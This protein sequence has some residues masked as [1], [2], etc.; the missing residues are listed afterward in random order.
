MF[1]E[2]GHLSSH[3]IAP[4]FMFMKKENPLPKEPTWK[5]PW[6]ISLSLLPFQKAGNSF[7]NSRAPTAILW[8]VLFLSFR[9]FVCC[10]LWT[11]IHIYANLWSGFSLCVK[12]STLLF[13]KM[14][15]VTP[16]LWPMGSLT[17]FLVI[18]LLI[19]GQNWFKKCIQ[20]YLMPWLSAANRK[21]LLNASRYAS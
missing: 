1:R 3:S 21:T 12:F 11:L 10:V 19:L 20:L 8:T 14:L 17:L 6:I 2:S 18:I 7:K 15:F 4:P 13:R 9:R 5:H 16:F